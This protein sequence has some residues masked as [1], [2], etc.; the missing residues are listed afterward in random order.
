LASVSSQRQPQRWLSIGVWAELSHLVAERVGAQ[1]CDT[2]AD[3]LLRHLLAT[4]MIRRCVVAE[5]PVTSRDVHVLA[6]ETARA[7]VVA[8]VGWPRRERGGM[9]PCG[10]ALMQRSVRSRSSQRGSG[11]S[12]SVHRRGRAGAED[13][14]VAPGRVLRASRSISVAIAS[15]GGGRPGPWTPVAAGGGLGPT[16]GNPAGAQIH[17][18]LL[19]L[20]RLAVDV[21]RPAGGQRPS[22]EAVS[23]Y[24][25]VGGMRGRR[26]HR[27]SRRVFDIL[28][29]T[30]SIS[31]GLFKMK[32]QLQLAFGRCGI[33]VAP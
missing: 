6:Y 20:Q 22:A 32:A 5:K 13:G 31:F 27:W 16:S 28:D 26:A 7:G 15:S 2:A 21:V 14:P 10:R 23:A 30:R 25:R 1:N 3:L 18:G 4:G 9:G 33:E 8:A 19:V 11:V 29:A 24:G 12:R 17:V